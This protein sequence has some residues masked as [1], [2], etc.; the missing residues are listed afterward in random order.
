M[1]T[2]RPFQ[3]ARDLDAREAECW[4]MFGAQEPQWEDVIR[5]APA[6]VVL[7]LEQLYAA[8]EYRWVP[9]AEARV[10]DSHG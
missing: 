2:T 3:E 5:Q 1:T 6:P 4:R 9:V 10:R 8:T 7:T